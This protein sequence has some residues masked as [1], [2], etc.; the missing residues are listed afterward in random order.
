VSV[1]R[2][3]KP[4][5]NR[6]NPSVRPGGMTAEVRIGAGRPAGYAGVRRQPAANGRYRPRAVIQSFTLV[7][8]SIVGLSFV[9]EMIQ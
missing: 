3:Q 1:E 9:N 7:R 8:R 2:S 4:P 5:N 6:V